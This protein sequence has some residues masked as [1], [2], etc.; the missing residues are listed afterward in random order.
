MLYFRSSPETHRAAIVL[1]NKTLDPHW[2][3]PGETPI[4]SLAAWSAHCHESFFARNPTA[5]L[6][7]L[8]WGAYTRR[9]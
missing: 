4:W 6:A 5:W 3:V 9:P 8:R 2:K 7:P 1:Q